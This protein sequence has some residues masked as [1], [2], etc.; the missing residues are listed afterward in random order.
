MSTHALAARQLRIERTHLTKANDTARKSDWRNHA[1]WR[2][3]A[4]S[5]ICGRAGRYNDACGGCRTWPGRFCAMAR[6]YRAVRDAE[7][8]RIAFMGSIPAGIHRIAHHIVAWQYAPSA[9]RWNGSAVAWVVCP[10]DV[11]ADHRTEPPPPFRGTVAAIPE[12]NCGRFVGHVLF[13]AIRRFSM[14]VV[15][16]FVMT[17]NWDVVLA[18]PACDADG[19]RSLH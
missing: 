5:S 10:S 14:I 12:I 16:Q 9:A 15:D 7:H 3:A 1:A 11:A 6:A 2:P 18:R 13:H 19:A 17:F 4:V 8:V